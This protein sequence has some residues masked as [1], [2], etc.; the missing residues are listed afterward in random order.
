MYE[1]IELF[2]EIGGIESRY[3]A[4]VL[5][6]SLKLS[7][8]ILVLRASWVGDYFTFSLNIFLHLMTDI[9]LLNSTDLMS[10]AVKQ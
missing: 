10:I 8:H 6:H 3:K 5:L 1:L 2:V 4:A 7:S 9:T